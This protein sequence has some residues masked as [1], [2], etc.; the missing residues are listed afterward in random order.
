LDRVFLDANIL[1]SA[2]FRPRAGLPKLWRLPDVTLITSEHAIEEARRNLEEAGQRARLT[3]LLRKVEVVGFRHFTL[4]RGI[5]LPVQDR[6]ILL[7]A[8]D[9]AATHLLTG[10]WEHFGLYYR[11]EIA[12]VLILPPAEYPSFSKPEPGTR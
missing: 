1:L 10:D 4:P 9:G 2:A 8:I 11:Q 6:P 7:A 3:R 5:V 12:G